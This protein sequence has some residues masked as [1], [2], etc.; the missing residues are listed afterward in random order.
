MAFPKS[1]EKKHLSNVIQRSFLS[2]LS[3]EAKSGSPMQGR[4][5]GDPGHQST[6]LFSLFQASDAKRLLAGNESSMGVSMPFKLAL[7]NDESRFM[8]METAEKKQEEYEN[9]LLRLN[10]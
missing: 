10:P 1:Q 8:M 6:N 2:D 7:I 5:R 3:G 9:S 4:P